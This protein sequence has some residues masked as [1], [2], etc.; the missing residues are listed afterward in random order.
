[1]KAPIFYKKLHNTQ[2]QAKSY[3]PKFFLKHSYQNSFEL[4]KTI[5]N[6]EEKILNFYTPI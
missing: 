5:S 4:V 1:M 3:D 6:K 2:E